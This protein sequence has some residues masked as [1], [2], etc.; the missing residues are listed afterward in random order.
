MC[1]LS[2]GLGVAFLLWFSSDIIA[3]EADCGI[4][5]YWERFKDVNVVSAIAN[6]LVLLVSLSAY[7]LWLKE[8]KVSLRSIYE[9]EKAARNAEEARLSK[10]N[11]NGTVEE[12]STRIFLFSCFCLC[13]HTNF[14]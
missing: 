11:K 10:V 1:S 14:L 13:G 5:Q 2:L 12:V 6:V 7:Y 9:A 3:L 4:T 8:A